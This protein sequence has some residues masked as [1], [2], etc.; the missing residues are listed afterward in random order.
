M[1]QEPSPL[2]GAACP[3]QLAAPRLRRCPSAMAV[4]ICSCRCR[5]TAE[6]PAPADSDALLP[7]L[8][9]DCQGHPAC[10]QHC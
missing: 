7:S 8:V 10:R 3:P 2:P 6:L 9:R 5:M 1:H 4:Y